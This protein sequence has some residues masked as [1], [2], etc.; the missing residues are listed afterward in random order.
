M[1]LTNKQRQRLYDVGLALIGV[2][3]IYGL[4]DGEQAAAW[5]LVLAPLLGLARSNV[6]V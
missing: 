1:K 5:A 3:S 6:D 4:I 2:V